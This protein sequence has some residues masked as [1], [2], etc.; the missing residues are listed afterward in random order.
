M[1]VCIYCF[2]YFKKGAIMTIQIDP[3][4]ENFM[5]SGKNNYS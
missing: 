1:Y 3:W 4:K 5:Q 2:L